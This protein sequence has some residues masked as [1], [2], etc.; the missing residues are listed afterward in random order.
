MVCL[1]FYKLFLHRACISDSKKLSKKNILIE[2]DL[3]KTE[4][5][6]NFQRLIYKHNHR[7][8]NV[9]TQKVDACVNYGGVTQEKKI[10][11]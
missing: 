2:N 5:I 8:I 3:I 9:K 7:M 4:L 1:F 11:F 10:G 6:N